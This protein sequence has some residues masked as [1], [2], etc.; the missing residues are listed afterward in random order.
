MQGDFGLREKNSTCCFGK[1]NARP[2][3][4][5]REWFGEENLFG[6]ILC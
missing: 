5:L 2:V 6:E 4:N 3:S 1:H